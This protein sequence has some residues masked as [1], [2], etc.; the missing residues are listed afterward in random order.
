MKKLILICL[1]GY[2]CVPTSTLTAQVAEPPPRQEEVIPSAPSGALIYGELINPDSLSPLRLLLTEHKLGYRNTAGE[3]EI[4]IE[5]HPGKFLDGVLSGT[6]KKFR[7]RLPHKGAVYASLL[8]DNRVLLEDYVLFSDDS[9]M[10]SLDLRKMEVVFGGPDRDWMDAQYAVK[11]GEARDTF[12][13]RRLM[14]QDKEE[15]LDRH[16]NRAEWEK[17]KREFGPSLNIIELG[18]DGADQSY[19]K[20]MN[21]DYESIPGWKELQRHKADLTEDQYD[22]LETDLIGNYFGDEL[23][24]F[25]QYQYGVPKMKGQQD[26]L[27]RMDLMIPE[28]ALKLKRDIDSIAPSTFSVGYNFLVTLWVKLEQMMTGD[29]FENIAIANFGGEVLDRLLASNLMYRVRFTPEKMDYWESYSDYINNPEWKKL[30][31]DALYEYRTGQPVKEVV[32]YS[33]DGKEWSL[34]DFEG[35][36]TLF[37]FYF[38]TCSN[39]EKYF[40]NYL[41]PLYQETADQQGY[42]LV[43]VSVDDDPSLWR[44]NIPTYSS[45]ELLNLNL[46]LASN[47]EW[48]ER[49]HID[50]YPRVMLIDSEGKLLSYN[51]QGNDYTDY[52]NRFLQVLEK[53]NENY[54]P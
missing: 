10:M 7:L 5:L 14:E 2:L 12:Y 40:K 46:P 3:S 48:L 17:Y 11:R 34:Q 18:R 13:S 29:S 9:V 37:Y 30:A 41:W 8:L 52:R 32:F 4:L 16:N 22:L 35:T 19:A 21:A 25:L 49:Y 36:P 54:T 47:K 38:S 39:S 24:S 6:R 44:A 51:L 26:I 31:G 53:T 27:D 50:A 23:R 28:L 1:L 20:M 45:P 42:R 43:A 33:Q 15:F